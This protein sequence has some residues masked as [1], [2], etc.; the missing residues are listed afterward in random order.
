MIA[1]LLCACLGHRSLQRI[2][3]YHALGNTDGIAQ[4]IQ[5]SPHAYIR[6]EAIQRFQETPP[7]YWSNQ[8]IEILGSCV[9]SSSEYCYISSQCARALGFAQNTQY[10]ESITQKMDYCDSESR[11]H[12]LLALA[13]LQDSSVLARAKIIELEQDIDLLVRQKA[14]DLRAEQ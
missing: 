8:S 13:R 10:V 2:E 9:Q 7:Q 14:I 3:K 5:T 4:I 1:W 11:Y 6:F 12:F